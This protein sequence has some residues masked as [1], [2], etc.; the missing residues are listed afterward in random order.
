M[1][2]WQLFTWIVHFNCCASILN[3][4]QTARLCVQSNVKT[5][6]PCC[7]SELPCDARHLCRKLAP[8][9]R[10]TQSIE[11]ILKLSANVRKL[12]KNHFTSARVKNWCMS[13][14]G[15]TGPPDQ[16]SRNSGI[17]FGHISCVRYP[18]WKNSAPWK[19]RSKF[20]LDHQTCH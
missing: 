7:R 3:K 12:L 19:S 15:I 1:G 6:R 14:H 10:A 2:I 20:T 18:L 11:T 16:S 4:V 17:S 13:Q 9:L 8:N 5:R